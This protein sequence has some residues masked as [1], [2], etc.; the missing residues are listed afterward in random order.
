MFDKGSE[1]IGQEF[2]EMIT[3]YII[4]P[5]HIATKNPQENAIIELMHTTLRDVLRTFEI[6][7]KI[8]DKDPWT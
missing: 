6:D 4:K 5:K 8:D 2:R 7:K 3:T 1:C